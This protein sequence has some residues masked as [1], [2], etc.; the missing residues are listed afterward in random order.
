MMDKELIS[1]F[2]NDK[3]NSL[4]LYHAYLEFEVALPKTFDAK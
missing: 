4:N 3:G 2:K 1:Q